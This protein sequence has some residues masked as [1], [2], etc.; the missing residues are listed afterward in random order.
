MKSGDKIQIDK[1]AVFRN[2]YLYIHKA[3]FDILHA[4]TQANVKPVVPTDMASIVGNH[5]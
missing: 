2:I 5:K 4:G 1:S 3:I